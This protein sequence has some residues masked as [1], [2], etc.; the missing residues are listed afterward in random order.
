MRIALLGPSRH[1]VAEPFAGGQES[2]VAT[3]ARELRQRGHWVTLF[4][5]AGSD[6]N[7]AD[8]L[9][10]FPHLPNFSAVAAVDPQLPEPGFLRDQHAFLTV[11]GDLMRRRADFDVVHNNSLHHLPLVSAQ[12]IGLPLVVTLHTPPFPW[13]EL[14]VALCDPRA[15]FVAVSESLAHQWTALPNPA[16]VIPSGVPT[17]TF[18]AGAGGQSAVWVGRMV[19]EKGPDLAITAAQRAGRALRLIGPIGDPQ[20]FETQVQPRLGRNTT[21]DGHLTQKQTASVVGEAALLL[22]T[23]R[24]EEPF[25]LVAVEAALT[26]TPV[27]ALRR[28]GLAEVVDPQMGLLVDTRSTDDATCCALAENVDAVA[29]MS[30]SEVRASAARRFSV[31]TMVSRY[32]EVYRQAVALW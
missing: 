10:E 3:L 28:G 29:S 5:A 4:A 20:W 12:A 22:M 7:L 9:V 13:M 31:T 32:E 15:I 30:R 6:P 1:P 26:G 8:E 21:Y 17:S 16:I 18:G 14:G 23:P 24:W 11:V 25:G 19:A 27:L 2:Y